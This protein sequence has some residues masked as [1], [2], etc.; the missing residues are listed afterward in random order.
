MANI[1]L[2]DL[3]EEAI[4][5]FVK[6]HEDLYDKTNEHFKDKARK[7]F[8]GRDS[9]TVASCLSRCA[10][11]GLSLKGL[12]MTSSCNQNLECP[13]RDDRMSELDTG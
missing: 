8:S 9:P 12:I 10:R 11:P 3:H 2:T 7:A 13:E 4:A 1:Y 6:D 5:G